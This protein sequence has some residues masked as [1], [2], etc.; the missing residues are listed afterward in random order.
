MRR[1]AARR[2]ERKLAVVPDDVDVSD[3][4]VPVVV[5]D[6]G[7]EPDESD[8]DP[9]HAQAAPAPPSASTVTEAAAA[10]GRFIWCIGFS[11]L[12]LSLLG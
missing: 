1:T 11:D 2:V 7:Y 9:P 6:P 12:E 3:V 8:D 10:S 4:D 5:E